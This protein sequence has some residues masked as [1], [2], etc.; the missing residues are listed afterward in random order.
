LWKEI[1]GVDMP[2]QDLEA[3]AEEM[4]VTI[5]ELFKFLQFRDRDAMTACGLSVAQCYMVDAIGMQGQ[6]TLNELAESLY[7]TPSTASRTVDDL[8]RKGLVER[9]QDLADRRAIRL[10][11]TPPGQALYEALRRHLIQR[12]MT[13]LEQLDPESRRGVLKALQQLFQAVKDPSCCAVPF[14]WQGGSTPG[15][16]VDVDADSTRAKWA[17]GQTRRPLPASRST[18][19]KGARHE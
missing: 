19:Q 14:E 11:L 16:V 3:V 12:Q 6:L 18:Q 15:D 1:Y 4:W 5:R 7:V 10:S 17:A 8:V 2:A 13:I 9:R